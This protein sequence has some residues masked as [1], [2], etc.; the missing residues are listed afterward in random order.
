MCSSDLPDS[1]AARIHAVRTGR[2]VA[3]GNGSGNDLSN[4]NRAGRRFTDDDDGAGGDDG[5]DGSD[6]SYGDEELEEDHEAKS[7]MGT[8]PTLTEASAFS[9]DWHVPDERGFSVRPLR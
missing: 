1:L 8:R 2:S 9:F 6:G 4:D 3:A 5:S 7:V